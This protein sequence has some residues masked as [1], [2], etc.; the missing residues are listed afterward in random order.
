MEKIFGLVYN[1]TV[2]PKITPGKAWNW[3]EKHL[4]HA[5]YP[6]SR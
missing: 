3:P 5:D 6:E 1:Y 4:R 2:P